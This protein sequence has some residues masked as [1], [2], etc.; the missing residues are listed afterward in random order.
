MSVGELDALDT[1]SFGILERR[2]PRKN[3]IHPLMPPHEWQDQLAADSVILSAS[4]MLQVNAPK[5]LLRF[6]LAGKE[7]LQD[8]TVFFQIQTHFQL[9]RFRRRERYIAQ[10][11]IDNHVVQGVDVLYVRDVAT[12][13]Q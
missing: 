13:S 11:F 7:S 4:S 2:Q 6:G 3:L 9:I 8:V 5:R 10:P 12:E 1:Q